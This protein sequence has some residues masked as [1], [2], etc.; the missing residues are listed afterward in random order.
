MVDSI[1]STNSGQAS[2][3]QDETTDRTERV[4]LITGGTGAIGRAAAVELAKRGW[5]IFLQHSA[6]RAEAQPV[7]QAVMQAAQSPSTASPRSP[8]TNSGQASRVCH[9]CC[10]LAVAAEREQLVDHV[11]DELGRLDMLVLTPP[12]QSL[13]ASDVLELTEEMFFEAMQGGVAAGLF[14]AQLV[15]NEM[16]RMVEAGDIESP[17]IVMMN[18]LSAYTTSADQAP[19]CIAAA[20]SAM[21]AQLMAD[22]LGEHGINV[23]EMRLGI[24]SAGPG[25]AAHARYDELIR[26]GLTPLRRFGRPGDAARAVAA[27]ADDLLSFSTGE[28]INVDGGFHLRRM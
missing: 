20:A 19:Q 2:S 26:R 11:L 21:V 3:P 6:S 12:A 4:A 15:A 5:S 24:I 22:R 18:T 25:D 10:D 28:V 1:R 16:V 23:Y 8:Q 17:R 14:L 13:A 27:I 7:V 9:R